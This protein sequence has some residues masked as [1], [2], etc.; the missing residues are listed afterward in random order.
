VIAQFSKQLLA[1]IDHYGLPGE[2]A[3]QRMVPYGRLKTSQALSNNQVKPKIGAVLILLYPE[4]NQIKNVLIK[5]P[6]YEGVHSGQMAFPGGKMEPDDQST[7]ATALREASEEIGLNTSFI[8]PLHSLTPVYIPPSNF[9]VHPWM[10]M[11]EQKPQFIPDKREVHSIH[12]YNIAD[13]YPDDVIQVAN[14]PSG[15][16]N[17]RMNT[18][19]FSI[20]NEVVWGAT[21]VMLNEFR[22]LILRIRI[23]A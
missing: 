19:Y 20:N 3:H 21:A 22:E 1:E 2:D 4:D 9:L 23:K 16:A 18:P 14:V 8:E 13:L 7:L 17:L 12:E 5:R 6:E 10:A 11:A 15:I